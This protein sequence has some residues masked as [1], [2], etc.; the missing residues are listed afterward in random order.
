MAQTKLGV[1]FTVRNKITQKFTK[2]IVRL[3][4]ITICDCGNHY[5]K[6]I[7]DALPRVNN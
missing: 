1:F 5:K 7:K 3:K 6:K 4:L 2:S